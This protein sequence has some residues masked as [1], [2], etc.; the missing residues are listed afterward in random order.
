MAGHLHRQGEPQGEASTAACLAQ[1]R[2]GARGPARL[3][4]V[5]LG[6]AILLVGLEGVL[7]VAHLTL[8]PERRGSALAP[9][10]RAILCI[11]DSNTYGIHLPPEHSYPGRLQE[12][13]DTA[14]GQPW[15]VVNLGY[16]GQNSAQV[17]AR[18]AQNLDHFRPEIV[19]CWI[20]VNNTWSPAMGHLWDSP[21]SET[22]A[23]PLQR[24]LQT[25]R[26]LGALRMLRNHI[27]PSPTEPARAP[28]EGVAEA[29]EGSV[30]RAGAGERGAG[31]GRVEDVRPEDVVGA[32]LPELERSLRID[33]ARIQHITAEHGARL[34]LVDY[35]LTGRSRQ[36]AV[37]PVLRAFASEQRLPL[38]RAGEVLL[39]LAATYGWEQ[40]LFPDHHATAAGNYAVAGAVLNE[41]LAAQLIEERPEWRARAPFEEWIL[42]SEFRVEQH[43]QA[44]LVEQA[45][46]T[47]TLELEGPAS[48]TWWIGVEALVEKNGF[49]EPFPVAIAKEERLAREAR[50]AY[51]GEFEGEGRSRTVLRLPPLPDGAEPGAPEQRWRLTANA[52]P[53][54]EFG[55]VDPTKPDGFW[56]VIEV[57]V[58]AN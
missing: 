37:N 6:L 16:P 55:I 10:E 58:P 53:P 46:R 12:L 20:G 51:F 13:L 15:R 25:S 3:V 47:V 32:E 54:H 56:S 24:L 19:I 26:A 2:S 45:G 49:L 57:T 42:G 35:P 38:V 31:L 17:R 21:D 5:L 41:L 11:G 28:P 43:F 34:V 52:N 33:I 36:A 30:P 27:V 48:W 22:T 4:A 23:G 1:R 18:L 40:V 44:R 9:G 7:W 50:A 39:S 29:F 8:D 14:P